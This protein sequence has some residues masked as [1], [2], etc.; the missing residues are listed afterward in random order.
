MTLAGSQTCLINLGA[1]VGYFNGKK[2]PRNFQDRKKEIFLY[3][4]HFCLIWKSQAVSFIEAKNQSANHFIITSI[5]SYD[6]I[7]NFVFFYFNNSN[8]N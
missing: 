2:R 7:F 8:F 3:N 6:F 4:N 5:I 1:E